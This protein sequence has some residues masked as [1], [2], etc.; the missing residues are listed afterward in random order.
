MRAYKTVN[1]TYIEPISFTVPRRAET[2][3]SD[4][5]PPATGVKPAM[6]AQEW[7]DGNEGLPAKIDLESVYEG[8]A[9]KEVPADYKPAPKPAPAPAAAAK[10]A[11]KKEDA[12]PSTP[13]ARGP[14]PSMKDQQASISDMASKFKDE[15][16]EDEEE[17]S[18]G[19]SSFEKVQRPQPRGPVATTS[20]A[21]PAPAPAPAAAAAPAPVA[22]R[23][24]PAKQPVKPAAPVREQPP[25]VG[26]NATPSTNV[27]ASNLVEA[28]LEEIKQLLERQST[29]ISSQNE[30]IGQLTAEVDSLKRKV[31]S[32]AG[33]PSQD[34]SERIRQLELELEAARG[35]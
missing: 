16:A 20:A 18:D 30:R 10:P 1:D 17:S 8:T 3:Q 5:F 22:R 32:A 4:I 31:G 21:A 23:P 33:G 35:D 24:E 28:S 25:A 26:S 29:L 11:P 2:F 34:Q 7:I 14:P 27:N 6:S 9:P 13:V 15:E 19:D 12:E